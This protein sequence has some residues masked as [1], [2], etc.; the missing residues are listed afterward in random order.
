MSGRQGS[1]GAPS[2]VS[3]FGRV[4]GPRARS[5]R[6]NARAACRR[7]GDRRR[8]SPRCA[9]AHGSLPRRRPDRRHRQQQHGQGADQPDPHRSV[10]LPEPLRGGTQHRRTPPDLCL[11]QGRRAGRAGRYLP[12]Q[13]VHRGR[14][15]AERRALR[16]ARPTAFMDVWIDQILAKGIR[17]KGVATIFGDGNSDRQLHRG[18]RRRRVRREDSRDAEVVN[19]VGRSRRAVERLAEP[20]RHARR[21]PLEVVREAPART[22]RGDASAPADRPAVQRGCRP[23]DDTG[24]VLRDG[25]EA[26]PGMEASADRFGVTP[27]TVETYVD[28]MAR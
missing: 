11:L 5:Q 16:D 14:D 3:S 6:R 10:R 17:E 26:V 24:P 23:T 1:S 20:P 28:Q 21:A 8:R 12:G 15:Q 25:S 22:G 27:R 2:P 18:G 7:G 9:E 19:E 13:V 4:P